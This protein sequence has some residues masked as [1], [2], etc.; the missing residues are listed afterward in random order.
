MCVLVSS[1]VHFFATP[2]II[3]I[4]H[5]GPLSMESLGK[6][7]GVGCHSRLGDLPDPEIEHG[8]PSLQA[9]SLRSESPGKPHKCIIE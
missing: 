1:H 8:S 6:S 3:N 9:D 7:A 2:W 5:Q 4:T